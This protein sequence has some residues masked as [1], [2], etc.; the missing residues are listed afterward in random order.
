MQKHPRITSG[1]QQNICSFTNQVLM[2]PL[3]LSQYAF[4][5]YLRKAALINS[6]L[7]GIKV[8]GLPCGC[9]VWAYKSGARELSALPF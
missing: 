7:P 1:N 2:Q 8:Y 4:S 3:R 6:A 9:C 5:R